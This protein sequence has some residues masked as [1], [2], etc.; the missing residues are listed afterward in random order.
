MYTSDSK[1]FWGRLPPPLNYLCLSSFPCLLSTQV[2]GIL[3][4]TPP[5][6]PRSS[7]CS[8]QSGAPSRPI[9]NLVPHAIL[10]LLCQSHQTSHG[11][12]SE[13]DIIPGR[14]L[15]LDASTSANELVYA[16]ICPST[17]NG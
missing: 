10:P 12:L 3:E 16:L 5:K 14:V 8:A 4:L 7:E 15:H 17:K 2:M 1:V 6:V 9:G 11:R 13:L